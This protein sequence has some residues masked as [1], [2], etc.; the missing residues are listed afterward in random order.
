M[1]PCARL[2]R[3]RHRAQAVV[4]DAFDVGDIGLQRRVLVESHG[5]EVLACTIV[6]GGCGAGH[7]AH[8]VTGCDGDEKR[9]L[10]SSIAQGASFPDVGAPALNGWR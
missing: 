9:W 6:G 2:G 5:R 3:R 8:D 7:G 4:E 1:M 10:R